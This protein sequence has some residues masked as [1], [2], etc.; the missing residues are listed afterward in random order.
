MFLSKQASRPKLA[1]LLT[2]GVSIVVL[3]T[4]LSMLVLVDHF[5]D[6]YAQKQAEQR[7]QQLSWQMRDELDQVMQ[8]AVGDVQLL[9][10]L[11]QIKDAKEP[12]D[13]RNIVDTLQTTFP[14]YA[15]IGFAAPD[16][17]VIAA[18][19]GLLEGTDVSQRPWFQQGQKGLYIGDYHPALLLQK[20]MP[21]S[22]DPWRF[23]DVS[24][25]IRSS[26]GAYRGVIGAHLSWGWAREMAR[27]LLSPVNQQYSAEI[28][29]VRED[30]TVIL[31]PS[32]MEEKK[33]KSASLTQS[34]SGKSGATEEK[35][36]DGQEYLTG[37]ALTGNQ[38]NYPALKWSI[39]VR[40]RKDLA[41]AALRNLEHEIL[42]LGGVLAL[43]LAFI[44]ALMAR[45]LSSSLIQLSSSIERR[46]QHRTVESIPIVNGF[47]EAHLL[48]VTLADMVKKEWQY[49][50]GIERVNESLEST[51]AERTREIE[52]KANEL[53]L[54]LQR[55]RSA[56]S[57]LQTITDNLPSIITFMDTQERYLFVSAFVTTEF[58]VKPEQLIGKTLREVVGNKFYAGLATHV[59]KVLVGERV[60]FE[61][62]GTINNRVYYYQSIY[63]PALN[64]VGVV[65]G[66]YAMS[67]DI[68]DRKRVEMM[69]NEFVS[70]VSHELRTPLTSINGALRLLAAGVAGE[71]P[72]KAKELTTVAMRNTDRLLRLIND[73]LDMEKIASGNMEF[74]FKLAKLDQL[75]QETISTNISYADQY[76]VRIVRTGNYGDV[77]VNVDRDRFAQVLTNLLSNAVKFS[78]EGG[79]VRVSV[80]QGTKTVK[81]IVS[82]QGCGIPAHFHDK[83][84]QKFS[85]VDNSNTRKKG[86]TGLGLNIC[87]TIIE[88]MGG[89]IG[90]T[91]TVDVG[92]QFFFELPLVS[93]QNSIDP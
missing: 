65:E 41:M 34:R 38:R 71:I 7:L 76:G 31:G 3:C 21:Y 25:P 48:S 83:I 51:V 54:S 90:F 24:I 67:F 93:V 23:V 77:D 50:A 15:W 70:T 82:D 26:D 35:W 20:Q 37:Y 43:I 81:L 5:A 89:T 42:Y 10:Q 6:N 33:I 39:L 68:A 27:T 66:F 45:R 87:K 69:K 53:E 52:C 17:K 88:H 18:T 49:L 85:Q 84:F 22:A 79:E 32:G 40:Q 75:I 8:R 74:N 29:V 1:T 60:S 28:L 58:G 61:A 47:H 12:S 92:S 44:A 19:K 57:R 55:Q 16:G 86:G 4:V 63:V 62:E 80:E 11:N 2:S 64:D 59:Q 9:S 78:H 73:I 91:S 72:P 30:G 46:G 13:I 14:S 36:E 56:Q